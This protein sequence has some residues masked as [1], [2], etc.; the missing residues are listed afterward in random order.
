MPR[1][2]ASTKVFEAAA[3][4]TRK[5]RYVLRLYVAGTT[6]GSTRA[7]AALKAIC[8]EHLEGRYKLEVIDVYQEP[9]VARAE[10]I[11]ALPT[12]VKSLPLPMRRILGDLSNEGRVLMGL[13][14]TPATDEAKPRSAK[15]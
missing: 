1:P 4:R 9:V 5:E 7:V 15:R 10:Q 6:A 3:S 2:R 8:E 12:L 14:L 13:D 11:V